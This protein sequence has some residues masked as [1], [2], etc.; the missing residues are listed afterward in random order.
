MGSPSRNAESVYFR[1]VFMKSLAT[2]HLLEQCIFTQKHIGLCRVAGKTAQHRP[3]N[4]KNQKIMVSESVINARLSHVPVT[5]NTLYNFPFTQASLQACQPNIKSGNQ[6]A[7]REDSPSTVTSV[8]PTKKHRPG[9]RESKQ[10]HS[11][12]P[13]QTIR[14]DKAAIGKHILVPY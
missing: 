3:T 14:K 8:N 10:V 9:E 1:P 5:F 4:A 7:S 6:Q 12:G 11:K 13:T 2:T